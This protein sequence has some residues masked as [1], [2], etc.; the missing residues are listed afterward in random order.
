MEYK[1]YL[2]KPS[3]ASPNLFTVA[4]EGRGG[5]APDCLSGLFTTRTVAM[6]EI[7]RYLESKGRGD[8]KNAGQSGG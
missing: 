5:K 2:I 3:K 6:N 1:G 8:A 4:T 7:D